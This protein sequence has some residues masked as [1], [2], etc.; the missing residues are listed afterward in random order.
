M[1]DVI[2]TQ[3]ITRKYGDLLAVNQAS[4]KVPEA[5][6]YGFLGPNG[7]GKTT[8]IRM[9]LGLIRPN[10]GEIRI[11]DKPLTRFRIP[12][13][14][15]IGALV[16][17]PSLY[18]HLSGRDN[19][20]IT[21]RLIGA[22]KSRLDELL[23]QTGMSQAAGRLTKT[24]SLGMKQ[25]LGLAM[26]LLNRPKLLILDEPTNGLDP[27]GIHEMRELILALPK[28]TGVTIFLSSHLLHE[29]EQLADKVGIINK[30]KLLF[31][32]SI[33]E[34]NSDREM[35]LHLKVDKPT[36]SIELLKSRG[37]VGLGMVGDAIEL[38][39][40]READSA[41]INRL[42]VES[43]INVFEVR[44]KRTTLEHRFLYLTGQT[45]SREE[46]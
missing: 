32:G 38:L 7:S 13:L 19:L 36:E 28:E 18:G 30:G 22:P 25:R 15:K 20:E 2:S 37:S 45:E 16:E 35:R 39:V 21:R 14:A 41:E 33:E 3:A 8:T 10:E 12:I 31:E 26:A 1:P 43:G 40:E 24:Y 5:R 34:L 42:L 23:A 6:I 29:V 11:F 27:A 9:L 17:H 46:K 44:F 4:L